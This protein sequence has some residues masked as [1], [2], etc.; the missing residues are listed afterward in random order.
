MNKTL[1][2]DRGSFK[3]YEDS[4]DIDRYDPETIIEDII[5]NKS[6]TKAIVSG[7]NKKGWVYL[8]APVPVGT[9]RKY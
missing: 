8:A 1:D 9:K 4:K 7:S 5:L 3:E 6:C 2:E